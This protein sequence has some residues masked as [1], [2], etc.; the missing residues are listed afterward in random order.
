MLLDEVSTYLEA[1]GMGT[2]GTDLFASLPSKPDDVV[3][4]REYAGSASRYVKQLRAP[5]EERPRF[6]V[7]ARSK[8]PFAAR[9]RAERIYQLLDNF[10]GVLSGVTYSSIRALQPPFPMPLDENQRTEVVCNYEATKAQS[11][12][13]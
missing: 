11:P 5:V 7:V 3:A 2:R 6:Q 8:D 12:L 4:V 13:T 9:E 10:S 1:S